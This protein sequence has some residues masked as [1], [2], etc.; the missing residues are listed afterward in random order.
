[1][2]QGISAVRPTNG[3]LSQAIPCGI[4]DEWRDTGISF[5]IVF[6]LSLPIHRCSLHKFRTSI[7]E[8]MY[9]NQY[10]DWAAVWTTQG[11]YISKGETFIS[12]L[13][14]PDQL[15]GAPS[16]FFNWLLFKDR[17]CQFV[18]LTTN[19]KLVQRIRIGQ[20]TSGCA[21]NILLTF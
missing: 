16:L 2:P 8:G 14:R 1:M 19:L 5:Y 10:S 3:L 12:S 11:S 7:T 15:W 6:P 17:S 9:S 13:Q 18:R 4:C 20:K 21:K